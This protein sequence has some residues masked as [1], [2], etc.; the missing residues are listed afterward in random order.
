[1]SAP[2]SLTNPPQ[3]PKKRLQS[4]PNL[5]WW[6]QRNLAKEFE[7]E[8]RREEREKRRQQEF[9]RRRKEVE[10]RLQWMR[11]D[12]DEFH[13]DGPIISDFY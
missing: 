13:R 11:Q 2:Y 12:F 10:E 1:M 6:E 3:A 4:Y 8:R 5:G 7:A 9:E